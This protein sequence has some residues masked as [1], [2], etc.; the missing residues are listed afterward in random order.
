MCGKGES[1]G[2]RA[3]ITPV[4]GGERDHER[5]NDARTRKWRRRNARAAGQMSTPLRWKAH[6]AAG[7]AGVMALWRARAP[8][9]RLRH[10]VSTLDCAGAGAG[11]QLTLKGSA[12]LNVF[13]SAALL[14]NE[15]RRGA[16]ATVRADARV[17]NA[18]ENISLDRL[19]L[20][21]ELASRV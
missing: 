3:A 1:G 4:V 11:V 10:R 2:G 15:R 13:L 5:K 14:A 19:V 21:V 12:N 20:V 7:A 8:S 9:A 18:E 16:N 6:F 17:R